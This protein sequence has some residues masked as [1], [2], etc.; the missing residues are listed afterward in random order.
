[1]MTVQNKQSSVMASLQYQVIL[2]SSSPEIYLKHQAISK[3]T[4]TK[5]SSN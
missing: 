3:N 2:P 1:M 4:Q 5:A